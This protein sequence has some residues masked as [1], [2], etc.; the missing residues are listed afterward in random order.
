[1][2]TLLLI[3]ALLFP[4]LSYLTF[5]LS[6]YDHW[7]R[8]KYSSPIFVPF[9]GPVLVTVWIVVTG[10]SLLWVPLAWVLDIGT[11]A[12]LAAV[13][14]LAT[15]WWVTSSWTR[16]REFRAKRG[17]WSVRLTL[18]STGRYLAEFERAGQE[19]GIA[20][21]MRVGSYLD[22]GDEIELTG[23]DGHIARLIRGE[24]GAYRIAGGGPPT[25]IEGGHATAEV[26]VLVAG[27]QI[28]EA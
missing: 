12:F 25:E 27:W 7:R 15:E 20:G 3:A 11:L 19:L 4:A 14:Q 1:M 17:A 18:H 21:F 16:V 8:D 2:T 28:E 10:N 23:D 26:A 9:V 22:R 5:A 6:I 24:D 13:P